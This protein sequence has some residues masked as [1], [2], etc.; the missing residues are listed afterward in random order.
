MKAQRNR[1]EALKKSEQLLRDQRD[2]LK[3]LTAKIIR[4]QEEERKRISL[5]LHD[6]IGQTLTA[7]AMDLNLIGQKYL[8]HDRELELK[9]AECQRLIKQGISDIHHFAFEL[10]P[11]M[12]DDLGLLSAIES[13]VESFKN[14]TGLEVNLQEAGELQKL[15]IQTITVFYR[16]FQETLHNIVKHA[17][18]STVRININHSGDIVTLRVSDDGVGC[19]PEQW[20]ERT[21]EQG[22]LGLQGIRE[23]LDL[24]GGSLSF[25]STPGGGTTVTASAKIKPGLEKPPQDV[26]SDPGQQSQNSRTEYLD[27]EK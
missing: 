5:E 12:L 21:T 7:I 26:K 17:R 2:Q 10:H 23:R 3:D 6:E 11:P 8:S 9:L 24:I 27:Q 13:Q 15:D 4:V 1:I 19:D 22:G 14:R 25:E 20:A 18:A 16:V